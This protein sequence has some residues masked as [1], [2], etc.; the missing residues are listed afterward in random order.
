MINPKARIMLA[1]IIVIGC[2]GPEARLLSLACRGVIPLHCGFS[3][4]PNRDGVSQRQAMNNEGIRI[5]YLPV[6]L[7]AGPG[8]SE[9]Q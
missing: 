2:P 1:C 5:A 9:A 3:I 6:V 7:H 4:E 8:V